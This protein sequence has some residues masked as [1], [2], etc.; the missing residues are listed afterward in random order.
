MIRK[1]AE[2][3]LM[4]QSC[5]CFMGSATGEKPTTRTRSLYQLFLE[6]L[7]HFLNDYPTFARSSRLKRA[8]LEMRLARCESIIVDECL[9]TELLVRR[10]SPPVLPQF[11]RQSLPMHGEVDRRRG[12]HKTRCLWGICSRGYWFC[13]H[14]RRLQ[15][16]GGNHSARPDAPHLVGK[17]RSCCAENVDPALG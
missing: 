15:G 11:D 3:R 7:A 17:S 5:R 1:A 12:A 4:G 10:A 9:L 8:V 13:A 2:T 16:S 14:T 6:A